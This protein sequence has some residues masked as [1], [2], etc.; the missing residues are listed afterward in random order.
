MIRFL[1]PSLMRQRINRLALGGNLQVL[2]HLFAQGQV[3]AFHHP[4]A[5]CQS[6]RSVVSHQV[7]GTQLEKH[8]NT[9]GRSVVFDEVVGFDTSL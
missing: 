1:S 3:I 8:D 6:Q 4:F 7:H 9:I 5:F 2:T